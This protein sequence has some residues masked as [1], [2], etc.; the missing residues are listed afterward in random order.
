[1][2]EINKNPSDNTERNALIVRT[3]I[4]G[5][6]VNLVLA[7]AKA[8]TGLIAGSIAVV[9]DAVNNF[10]DV[11]S[12]ALTVIGIKLSERKPDKKHPLGYGRIEY[13]S[14]LCVAVL[15]LYAGLMALTESVKK[16]ITPQDAEYSVLSLV[17]I[18][19]AVAVKLILGRYFKKHGEKIGSGTL[20]ASGT[21][22]ISDAILS[23]SVLA[24]AL[25]RMTSGLSLEAYLGAVISVF[26]IRAGI[27]LIRETANELLGQRADKELTD[28]VKE[29]V[30]QE[31]GVLGAY[32]LLIN[33]YG[34]G[35]NYGSVNIEVDDVT[36]AAEIDWMSRHIRGRVFGQTGVNLMGIGVYSRNTM[37]EE[38]AGL[39]EDIISRVKAH[40][41]VI[42]VYGF[43]IDTEIHEVHFYVAFRFRV[44]AREE[45]SK[46]SSELEQIYPDWTF[47]LAPHVDISD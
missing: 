34:P 25:I 37:D 44:N 33:N 23:S 21:D 22:A 17:L 18:G 12:G 47:R 32:D 28:R 43:Y 20:V 29:L 41:G 6:V 36:T 24:C 16:M 9:L 39:R 10:S 11:L 13:L 46:I 30:C 38:A 35:K 31:E 45:L 27:D 15:V 19:I 2:T 4:I 40:P 5:I 42:R 7:S 8:V 14:T 26:I 3:S 1:M